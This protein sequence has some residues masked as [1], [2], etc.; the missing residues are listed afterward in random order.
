V[1]AATGVVTFPLL[2][3]SPEVHPSWWLPDEWGRH[4]GQRQGEN[5]R[6]MSRSRGQGHTGCFGTWVRGQGLAGPP[7]VGVVR[8]ASVTVAGRVA[9]R[10]ACF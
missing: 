2:G 3:S 8:G 7:L 10:A 6:R 9:V 4:S 5:K 1:D